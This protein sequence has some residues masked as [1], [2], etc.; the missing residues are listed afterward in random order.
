MLSL[1]VSGSWLSVKIVYPRS[2]TWQ[3]EGCKP[4]TEVGQYW[5]L[6]GLKIAQENLPVDLQY[7]NSPNSQNSNYVNQSGRICNIGVAFFWEH[8]FRPVIYFLMPMW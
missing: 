4:D 2:F 3:A 8:R 5:P 6:R 1:R 7:S